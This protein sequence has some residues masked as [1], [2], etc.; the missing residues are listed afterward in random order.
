MAGT[1]P[2]DVHS[3]TIDERLDLITELWESIRQSGEEI[4]LTDAQ[5]AEIER[6]LEAHRRNP[7]A[8]VP[9]EVVDAELEEICG[10]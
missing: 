6:R 8:A 2:F 4:P 10:S 7:D 9:W 1:L 5:V 3:L